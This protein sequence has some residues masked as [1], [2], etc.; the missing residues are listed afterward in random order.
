MMDLGGPASD[1]VRGMPDKYSQKTI[2]LLFGTASYCAYP[3]CLAPLVF[4]DR[5]LLTPTSRSRI[6]GR[7]SR[8]G[9]GMTR[10]IGKILMG[11]RISYCCAGSI[12]RR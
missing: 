10:S 5:G 3:G 2:K 1:T 11:L 8:R 12:T 6:S 4:K 7:K 9:L